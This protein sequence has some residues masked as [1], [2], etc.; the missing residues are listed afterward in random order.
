MLE[1]QPQQP[2]TETGKTQYP[3]TDNNHIVFDFDTWSYDIAYAAVEKETGVVRPFSY[4]VAIIEARFADIMYKL[5]GATYEGYLT[6]KGNFRNFVA[7]TDPY[8]GNRINTVKPPYYEDI[9][10]YLIHRF[11]AV[12]VH[13]YEA[14]D[15]CAMAV[16]KNRDAIIVSRDKDLRMVQCRQFSYGTSRTQEAYYDVM[17]SIEHLKLLAI[18]ILSGDTTD[19]YKGLKGVGK[20]TAEEILKNLNFTDPI[21]AAFSKYA[22]HNK[23][24]L[25][26]EMFRLAFMVHEV[27][28]DGNP[29]VVDPQLVTLF[30]YLRKYYKHDPETLEWI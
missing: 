5:K 4:C 12:V 14:D 25:F 15:A 6:G 7:V 18:Q 20:K 30:D 22:T 28:Q 9:R 2:E 24:G 26:F 11:S 19:N 29:V 16:H 27:D 3:S 13:G 1:L 21:L 17:P 23:Q 10:T 8:K